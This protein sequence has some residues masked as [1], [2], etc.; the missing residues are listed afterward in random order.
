[1][2]VLTNHAL[3]AAHVP[4]CVVPDVRAAYATVCH[5]LYGYPSWRL[6][7]IGV[8]GTNGKTTTTWL[9]R[10]ILES[11]GQPTGL[12]GTVE[13]SDSLQRSPARLTTPDSKTFAAWLSSMV[14]S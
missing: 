3:P 5:A 13:Y 8:T 14:A 4:Q 6:G 1:M 2:A 10:S 7:L 9:A 11:A 12:L